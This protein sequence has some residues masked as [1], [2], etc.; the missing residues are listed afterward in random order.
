[1]WHA[2]VCAAF[3]Y[4][5]NFKWSLGEHQQVHKMCWCLDIFIIVHRDDSYEVVDD[6]L[7]F[8]CYVQ[9]Y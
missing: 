3:H 8:I 7:S 2:W 5:P 9:Y 1:M 4:F 6:Y